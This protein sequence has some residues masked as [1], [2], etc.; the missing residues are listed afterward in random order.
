MQRSSKNIAPYLTS[1]PACNRCPWTPMS[2]GSLQPVLISWEACWRILR[3]LS[4]LRIYNYVISATEFR[5]KR[6]S[7]RIQKT[8]LNFKEVSWKK[9]TLTDVWNFRCF[10]S[11]SFIQFTGTLLT[12]L[13]PNLPKGLDLGLQNRWQRTQNT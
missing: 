8:Q 12:I 4:A 13:L 2:R 9:N 11:F 7:R 5:T 1:S 3:E 6:T 10:N